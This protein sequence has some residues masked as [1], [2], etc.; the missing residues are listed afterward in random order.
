M[1]TINKTAKELREDLSQR[2]SLR[3]RDIVSLYGIGL[4]TV[5]LYVK[6]GKLTPKKISPKITLF[7]AIEV[8]NFFNMK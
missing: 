6:E 4:S 3:A 7:S 5:W 1:R 2:E 8:S